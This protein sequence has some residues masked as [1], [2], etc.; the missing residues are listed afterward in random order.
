V[1]VV[2]SVSAS[3]TEYPSPTHRYMQDTVQLCDMG[4][5]FVGGASTAGGG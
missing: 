4:S 2:V 3:A 1:C 5:F